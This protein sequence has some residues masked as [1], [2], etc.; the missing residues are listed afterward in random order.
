MRE[1]LPMKMNW[2]IYIELKYF[3]LGMWFNWE[4]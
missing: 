3:R 1:V 4:K 2:L